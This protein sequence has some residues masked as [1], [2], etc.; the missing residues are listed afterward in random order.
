M[1]NMLIVYY[2]GSKFFKKCFDL[3]RFL[4]GKVDGWLLVGVISFRYGGWGRC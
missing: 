4:N 3:L 1:N 2:S